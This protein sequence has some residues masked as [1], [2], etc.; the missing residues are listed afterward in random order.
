MFLS[1]RLARR[2]EASRYSIDVD[3]MVREA[4]TL[5]DQAASFGGYGEDT[6]AEEARDLLGRMD[7]LLAGLRNDV[8]AFNAQKTA[9]EE[10]LAEAR[11]AENEGLISV[12][13]REAGGIA[14]QIAEYQAEIA[15]LEAEKGKLDAIANRG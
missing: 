7:D 6:S 9:I 15:E 1:H 4:G 12:L 2:P 8:E 3:Y 5:E 14:A 11:E 13:E 10:E